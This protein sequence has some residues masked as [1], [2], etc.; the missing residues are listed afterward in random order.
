MNVDGSALT[1]IAGYRIR[2]GTSALNLTQAIQV[3]TGT[4][5]SVVINSLPAGTYYFSV[6]AINSAGEASAPTNVVSKAVP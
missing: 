6:A 5:T 2:Y 4:S 1:N 3:S